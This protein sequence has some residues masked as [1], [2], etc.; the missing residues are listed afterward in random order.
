[1]TIEQV[2]KSANVSYFFRSS[3]LDF[4]FVEDSSIEFFSSLEEAKEA[5]KKQIKEDGILTS[6]AGSYAREDKEDSISFKNQG[7][8]SFI[9]EFKHVSELEL[10]E[11]SEPLIF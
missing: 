7:K 8:R 3:S 10:K 2:F 6:G 5:A 4:E 11:V 1:M 9:Y